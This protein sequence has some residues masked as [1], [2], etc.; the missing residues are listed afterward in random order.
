MRYPAYSNNSS[1]ARSNLLPRVCI[2]AAAKPRTYVATSK[3]QYRPT[4]GSRLVNPYLSSTLSRLTLPRLTSPCLA[5]ATRVAGKRLAN[6][7]LARIRVKARGYGTDFRVKAKRPYGLVARARLRVVCSQH[8]SA[9][10]GRPCTRVARIFRQRQLSC[11]YVVV[12]VCV[13]GR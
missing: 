10:T 2:D 6:A 11:R 1:L 9:S 3:I 13:R 7:I 8:A 12:F 4:T 5:N